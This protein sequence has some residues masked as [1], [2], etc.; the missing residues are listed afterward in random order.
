MAMGQLV[1]PVLLPLEDVEVPVDEGHHDHV[2]RGG[3][4]QPVGV[5]LQGLGL[6]EL[7]VAPL[8]VR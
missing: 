7:A 1:G 5:R 6:E 2:A 4:R 3:D 8:N